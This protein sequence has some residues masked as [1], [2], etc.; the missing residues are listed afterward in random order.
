MTAATRPLCVI[1]REIASDWKNVNY[2]AAPY[3]REMRG[4]DSINDRVGYD[5]ARS[6][7]RYF[8]A[9]AG[10]WR[11]EVAKRIKAE[12]KAAIAA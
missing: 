3:L 1:A 5:D 10:G 11:G 12:L 6:I 7:V 2:A 4:L 8:L 9:N